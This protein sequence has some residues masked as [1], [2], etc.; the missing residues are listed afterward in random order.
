[1][2]KVFQSSDFKKFHKL[3]R[4]D[5]EKALS[6]WKAKNDHSGDERMISDVSNKNGL[7]YYHS[8]NDVREIFGDGNKNLGKQKSYFRTV[9]FQMML[10]NP[11]LPRSNSLTPSLVNFDGKKTDLQIFNQLDTELLKAYYGKVYIGINKNLAAKLLFQ[12]L[13]LS[14]TSSDKQ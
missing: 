6:N 5:T 4:I 14:L 8:I 11:S 1:M 2:E 12:N 13:W 7:I 10:A 9:I 3:A